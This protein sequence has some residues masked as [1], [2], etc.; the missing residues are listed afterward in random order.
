MLE[1]AGFLEEAVGVGTGGASEGGVP[2]Q[3]R[4]AVLG[5]DLVGHVEECLFGR[6]CGGLGRR[7]G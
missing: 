3:G 6:G 5:A 4:D 1:F 2:L 7:E